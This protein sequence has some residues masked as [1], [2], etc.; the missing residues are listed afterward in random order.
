MKLCQKFGLVGEAKWYN[1]KPGSVVEND[2]VKILWDFNIQTDHVIHHRRLDIVVLYK[3]ERKCHLIDIA[4]LEEKRIELKEQERIDNSQLAFTC[5]KL[6]TENRNT[7]TR[8][9]ICSKLTVKMASITMASFW[10]L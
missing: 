6:T 1:H 8:C 4:V 10:C 2:R 7:R 5:S 9:E 3:T